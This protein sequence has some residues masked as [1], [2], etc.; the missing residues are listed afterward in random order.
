[1]TSDIKM[2]SYSC[3]G[4]STLSIQPYPFFS[5]LPAWGERGDLLAGRGDEVRQD[6]KDPHRRHNQKQH[7]T[8]QVACLPATEPVADS[9]RDRRDQV[10]QPVDD[11]IVESSAP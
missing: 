11:A 10:H 3:M 8:P 2:R 7:V 4:S 9:I 6:Q 5:P 1:M